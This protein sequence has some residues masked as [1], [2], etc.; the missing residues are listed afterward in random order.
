MGH[1]PNLQSP[2][3]IPL[4]KVG[5][6]YVNFIIVV[7]TLRIMKLQEKNPII[8]WSDTLWHFFLV[9]AIFFSPHNGMR[10]S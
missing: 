5:T 7:W 9:S 8:K 10:G 3:P 1:C 2:P 6:P 4:P